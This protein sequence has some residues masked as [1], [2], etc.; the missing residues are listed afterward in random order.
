M[1]LHHKNGNL[2]YLSKVSNGIS[3]LN[4][5]LTSLSPGMLRIPVEL[6]H[7]QMSSYIWI[8]WK[9]SAQDVGITLKLIVHPD[10]LES[11]R[12]FGLSHEFK[13]CSCACY[14]DKFILDKDCKHI[15]WKK[16]QWHGN[17][18]LTISSKP[19]ENTPKK[20]MP[21]W[22]VWSKLSWHFYNSSKKYRRCIHGHG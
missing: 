11:R 9:H 6:V 22:Y 10:N 16:L 3:T 7:Y 18:T 8:L 2:F 15:F 20:V 13:V 5:F 21:R 4:N 14:P 12:R 1:P 17:K 19:Q